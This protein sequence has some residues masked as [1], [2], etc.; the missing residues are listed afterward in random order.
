LLKCILMTVIGFLSGSVMYSY[1][2]PKML[3]GIDI[4]RASADGNPGS[5][6]AIAAAGV[7][8]GFFCMALDVL[9]AFIPVI[10]AVIIFKIRGEFLIPV[11][12]S[13]VLGHSFA[14]FLQFTGGK[15]VSTIY[16]A[17]LGILPLSKIV[18][19]VAVIMALFN[20]LLIVRPDSTKVILSITVACVL[21]L[22][23][24]PVLY[25]KIMMVLLTVILVFNHMRNPDKGENIVQIWRYAFVFRGNRLRFVKN[26]NG[27]YIEK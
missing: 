11:V 24:Q 4:T 21:S 7:K 16:G 17:L 14:P 23:L 9:K 19:L 12:V 20:F 8:I 1:F 26:R 25:I 6:N 10:A 18:F 22:F 15:G 27:F 2:I 3:R 5:S 13:P